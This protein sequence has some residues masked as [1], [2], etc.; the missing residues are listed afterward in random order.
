VITGKTIKAGDVVLGMASSGVHSNGFSL[1]RKVL[2]VRGTCVGVRVGGGRALVRV[3]PACG[4]ALVAHAEA[5]R[6]QFCVRA[7]GYANGNITT[8]PGTLN[9]R[10]DPPASKPTTPPHS[11]P[12]PKVSGTSLHD[13]CPWSNGQSFGAVLLEPT[14]IYVKRVLALHEKVGG[15]GV[16]VGVGVCA[17]ILGKGFQGCLLVVVCGQGLRGA[18]MAGRSGE[19]GASRSCALSL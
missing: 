4:A 9:Q 12:K 11:S 2:E 1:V 14:I 16:E 18:S 7:A 6:M 13:P 5:G 3:A 15:V 17:V 8:N 10:P 19:E